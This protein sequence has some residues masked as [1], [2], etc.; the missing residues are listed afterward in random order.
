MAKPDWEAIETAYRAGIMSLRD[1]GALYGVTEGAIRKKAKKLEWVRKNSTQKN[2]VR[3]T[4]RPASSGAVH[5][6]SQPETKPPADTKP[7]TVRKKVVTNHPPFQPGNQYALKH[8]GYARRLLLK[9]EVVEDARALTLEDELFRLRAN[10]LMAAEN[11]GRWFTL[12][13]DAEEE[14]QRKILMDNISAAEKAMMRNTVRIESIVGTLAT[15]SKIH[16][17]TDYRLA[18]T[19]K[20]SLEADRLRRDAG[21]DDGNGERDL[22]DFYADIQTDA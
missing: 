19:D 10:N 13:E 2:T 7:E 5:K 11:I 21:I 12:L 18:A 1:I 4:R 20:V 22:N 15:V 17:D 9:D 16:A 14:Q 8:G 3:T 6:H